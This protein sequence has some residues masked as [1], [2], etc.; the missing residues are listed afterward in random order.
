MKEVR[1]DQLGEELLS[2]IEWLIK[3]RWIAIG[4][5]FC[6]IIGVK[7]LLLVDIPLLSLCFGTITLL[8]LNFVY[9]WYS[10]RLKQDADFQ[11]QRKRALFFANLQI[12][13]DLFMLVFLIHFSG[14]LENPFIFYFIFHMVIASILLS[15]R[16]AYFQATF[17][18]VL[19]GAMIIL[20]HHHI[21]YHHHMQGFV[22]Y[23]M[24]GNI[25]YITGVFLILTSTLFITIYMATSIVNRLRA[26]EQELAIA[27]EQLSEQDRRKSQHV[28]T[29][30]HDIQS[31]LST[32]QSC[33]KV[34]LNGLTGGMP[35]KTRE[36]V[37][38]AEGRTLYLLHFTKDLLN[39]SR[40]KSAREMP[41]EEL[42][43][44]KVAEKVIEGIK[45]WSTEKGLS[46]TVEGT[47]ELPTVY[48]NRDEIEQL[49]LN[50][51]VN[52][53]KYTPKGGKITVEASKFE[54]AKNPPYAPFSNPD[55]ASTGSR[56]Q[57]NLEGRK[58]GDYVA[59]SVSDTGIGI[60]EDDLSHI[61]EEF[62]RAKN[63]GSVA[64][65][66]TGLG[67]SI[68]QQII[69]DHGGKIWAESKV[70]QGTKFTFLLPI[71]T[72]PFKGGVKW[73]KF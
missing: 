29:V 60:P 41:K 35:D 8:L 23:E 15:N 24:H 34:V 36:M 59:V 64:A 51:I 50:L 57:K 18:T 42:Q 56:I 39:L 53:I 9:F 11:H 1:E 40:I 71:G 63:T 68:A 43:L 72:V 17:A 65:E 14:G 19:L 27:N 20:E 58:E 13:V 33:L 6:V 38:R 16:A 3:L 61:F 69:K 54:Y 5:V 32:I 48:A 66:G 52:A 46:L 55:S 44:A 21:I 12:S 25:V 67:L 37:A 10:K 47:T 2:R 73:Q 45:M 22:P 4:G 30:A 7:F 26:R 31:H 28:W 49:F 62:Y 70:G